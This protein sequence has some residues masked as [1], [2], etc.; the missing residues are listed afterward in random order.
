MKEQELLMD[1]EGEELQSRKERGTHV[2]RSLV[3]ELDR[4]VPLLCEV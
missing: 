1:D 2:K 3:M 4:S